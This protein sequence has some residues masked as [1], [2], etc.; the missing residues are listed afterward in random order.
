MELKKK[1]IKKIKEKNRALKLDEFISLSLYE[2]DAYYQSMLPIGSTGDFVT[3]PEISQM[4]GEII[5][6]YILDYWSNNINS[7]FN[8]VELGPG[9]GTLIQ[10]IFRVA[11]LD[12][13]FFKSANIKLIEKNINLMKLQKNKIKSLKLVNTKWLSDFNIYSKLPSIIYSNEFFDCLPVRLFNKKKCWLEKTVDYNQNEETFF[14]KDRKVV[15]KNI[16]KYL[17]INK[18]KKIAEISFQRIKYFNK[19]CKYIYKNKGLIITIDYGYED[20]LK[21]FTLQ[22]ISA[23]K[24]THIFDYLGKQDITSHVNFKELI[25]IGKKNNLKI[26]FFSTQ[27]DFLI[28][29]GIIERKKKLI[30]NLPNAKKKMIQNQ[31]NLLTQN[32]KMGGNFKFLILSS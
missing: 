5:G 7:K 28:S 2:N 15:D 21:N 20:P 6:A 27:K 26:L 24:K 3:S 17:K 18:L 16:L 29:H 19:I 30:K 1:L 31:F 12:D 10:D 8:L 9:K 14:L 23:H 11:K 13:R 4:F 22:S 32:D 25:N